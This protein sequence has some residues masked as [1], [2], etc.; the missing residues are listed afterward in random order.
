[1]VILQT[2]YAYSYPH[3]SE[4]KIGL[5]TIMKCMERTNYQLRKSFYFHYNCSKE[6]GVI[7]KIEDKSS[8]N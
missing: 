6:V 4:A 1:M 2:S 3:T 7:K 8:S 5:T